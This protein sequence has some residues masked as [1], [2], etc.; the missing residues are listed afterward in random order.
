MV[1]AASILIMAAS[2]FAADTPEDLWT[3][4]K[5]P[6]VEAA[7]GL[8][9]AKKA[10]DEYKKWLKD[11]QELE[12]TQLDRA[13]DWF[14]DNKGKLEKKDEKAVIKACFWF[15][16]LADSGEQLPQQMRERMTRDNFEDCIKVLKEMAK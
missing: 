11:Q 13:L 10:R 14:N 6:L 3:E 12:R 16:S 8:I 2:L 7:N 9:D 4:F 5:A 15:V 1:R